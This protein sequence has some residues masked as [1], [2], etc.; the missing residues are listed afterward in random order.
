MRC[1]PR[2]SPAPHR[3]PSRST[4]GESEAPPNQRRRAPAGAARRGHRQ[5]RERPRPAQPPHATSRRATTSP[6]CAR[7]IAEHV[8]QVRSRR[9][10]PRAPRPA[11]P[12]PHAPPRDPHR[13]DHAPR[14]PRPPAPP[15]APAAP[16]RRLRLAA[17]A[18]ARLPALR[19]G[20]AGRDVH[21]R[22]PAHA[23][24]EGAAPPRRRHR[25]GSGQPTP[26]TTPTAAPGSAP[27]CRSSWTPRATRTARAARSRSCSPTASS[28]ATRR[29]MVHAVRR[30][31]RLSH[32]LLW[33]TPLGL[34]PTY[35]PITRAMA[36]IQPDVDLA[37]ARDLPSLL[38]QVRAAVTATSTPTTTSG[39]TS[40]LPWL[41]GPM[42]P[43]IFG[44]YESLQGKDY[45]AEEYIADVDA[46]RLHAVGLRADQL[47]ARA[48]GRRGRVGPRAARP[49][50]LAAR[51]RRLAPTCSTRTRARRSRR[52]P[53]P[54]R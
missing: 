43:R 13:R 52:R 28:A 25:A 5:E 49:H 31:K 19:L 32:R 1:S 44:P 54:A 42:I 17:R 41:A 18:H 24:H 30:L 36:A 46:A 8:P 50:R 26:S 40:E 20:R 11:R 2:T 47:A 48:R 12:A 22:H 6:S 9:L 37:G 29:Q 38:E 51:D 34:D 3:S 21:V 45:T 33:W 23:D 35:R 16:D 10:R 27:R 53:R 39:R 7:R 15:T 4:E 14:P